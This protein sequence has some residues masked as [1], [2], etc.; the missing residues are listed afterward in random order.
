MFRYGATAMQANTWYH[1][2]GVYDAAARTMDVYLNG[3]LD[4]GALRRHGHRRAAEL[5]RRTST[6]ASARRAAASTSTAASTTSG[7]TPGR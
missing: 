5:D 3:Q 6:S 1:I 7:S 4:N 2:A